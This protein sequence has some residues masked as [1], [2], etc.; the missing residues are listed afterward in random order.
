MAKLLTE[1]FADSAI[2]M[3]EKKLAADLDTLA[4]RS[5]GYY[6][7]GIRA[8]GFK[9]GLVGPAKSRKGANVAY[10]SGG[11]IHDAVISA[12]EKLGAQLPKTVSAATSQSSYRSHDDK[13]SKRGRS[14]IQKSTEFQSFRLEIKLPFAFK[15]E[16]GGTVV[17]ISPGGPKI[18][19]GLYGK[20]S[21]MG[22]GWLMWDDGTGKPKFA[23]SRSFKSPSE[24][25]GA[26]KRALQSTDD[27][28]RE[29]GWL[30]K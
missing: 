15:V 14:Q 8:E 27:L 25:V 13:A 3:L 9:E 28:A 29:L 12:I 20:R 2:K 23:R 18:E 6:L 17:P 16:K 7:D 26:L 19:N 10:E 30:R 22:S 21:R 1:N 5:V 24:G 11:Y 4:A